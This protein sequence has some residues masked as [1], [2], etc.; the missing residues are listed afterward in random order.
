VR[1]LADTTA[2]FTKEMGM[3]FDMTEVLGGIRSKRCGQ[4]TLTVS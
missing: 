4:P 2:A 1:M 3:E